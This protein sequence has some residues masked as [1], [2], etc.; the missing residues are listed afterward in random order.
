MKADNPIILSST[1]KAVEN[2]KRVL[3]DQYN[4]PELAKLCYTFDLFFC[5]YHDRTLSSLEGKTV[6]IDEFSMTPNK[7]MTQ[8][9]QAFT[10]YP[11][12]GALARSAQR[13]TMGNK[14]W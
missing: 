2:V 12:S 14:M 11:I 9:Y 13:S 5:D 4:R 10:K 7:W 6:F 1:N 8:I 3:T